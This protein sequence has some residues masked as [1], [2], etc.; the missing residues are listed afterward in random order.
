MHHPGELSVQH[1]AGVDG[2]AH[3]SATVGR[4]VP[5][6]SE[7]FLLEQ[8]MIV[9]SAERKDAVWTTV[10]VGEPGFIETLSETTFTIAAELPPRTRSSAPSTRHSRSA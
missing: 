2:V 4:D 10:L 5:A 8:R 1:R 6:V 7:Q 9:I 3:G